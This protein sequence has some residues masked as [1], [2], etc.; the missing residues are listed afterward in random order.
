M[1]GGWKGGPGGWRVIEHEA[2]VRTVQGLG[3][4]K[5]S[6]F[7]Q[8]QTEELPLKL[9]DFPASHGRG[10]V[11]ICSGSPGCLG[12]PLSPCSPGTEGVASLGKELSLHQPQWVMNESTGNFSPL[13][14]RGCVWSPPDLMGDLEPMISLL[15]LSF[16]FCTMDFGLT[17]EDLRE[18]EG[19]WVWAPTVCLALCE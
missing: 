10:K 1:I 18:A 7:C 4:G 11:R 12:S 8:N 13:S 6:S 14:P 2:G 9:Q 5:E 17:D 19:P 3:Q 15:C 16:D